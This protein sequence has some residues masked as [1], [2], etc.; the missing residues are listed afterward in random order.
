MK[1][2]APATMEEVTEREEATPL[3]QKKEATGLPWLSSE[4]GRQVH[5]PMDGMAGRIEK[6]GRGKG[7]TRAESQPWT[8][9]M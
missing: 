6:G 3:V 7:E 8:A 2:S 4:V 5:K 9:T 1:A